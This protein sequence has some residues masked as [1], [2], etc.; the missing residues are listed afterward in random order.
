MKAVLGILLHAP[1]LGFQLLV[2]VL[3]LLDQTGELPDLTFE[4]IDAHGRIV[5]RSLGETIWA[6]RRHPLLRLLTR[7]ILHSR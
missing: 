3:Q 2:A 7:A 1:D 6:R 4:A 5:T